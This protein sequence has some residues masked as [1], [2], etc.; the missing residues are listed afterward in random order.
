ML[1]QRLFGSSNRGRV[2]CAAIMLGMATE[3]PCAPV[4]GT[5][6]ALVNGPLDNLE[7]YLARPGIDINERGVTNSTTLLD[8]AAE[9]NNVAVLKYLLDHGAD[10]EATPGL[11]DRKYGLTALHHAAYFDAIDA[12]NFLILR[13]ARIDAHIA[14]DSSHI[15]T[16]TPLILAAQ[17]GHLRMV[18]VLLAHGADVNA[19]Y[20]RNQTAISDALGYGHVDVAH[21]LID[22]GAKLTAR[23]LNDAAMQGHADSVR[24]MLTLP[25]DA[26]AANEAILYATLRGPETGSEPKDI[27]EQLSA[28]GADIDYRVREHDAIPVMFATTPDMIDFLLSHGANGEAKLPGAQL[29]QAYVCNAKVK[30][31]LSVLKVLVAHGVD[32]GGEPS[33]PAV[34]AMNCAL[35]SRNAEVVQYLKNHEDNRDSTMRIPDFAVAPGT[36]PSPEVSEPTP[37]SKVLPPTSS[38]V[39]IIEDLRQRLYAIGETSASV[40]EGVMAEKTAASKIRQYVLGRSNDV[41]IL[42]NATGQTPLIEAAY[43]GYPQVVSALLEFEVVRQHVND[44]DDIGGTAWLYANMALRQS[45]AACNPSVLTDVFA[46][47]PLMV[48]Q[49]FYIPSPDSPYRVIRTALQNNG[50]TGTL[51]EAKRFWV[52]QCKREDSKTRARMEQSSDVLNT[53]THIGVVAFAHF[54]SEQQ[55]KAQLPTK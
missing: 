47:E 9:R 22:R 10:V 50:A 2:I 36:T 35:R 13:G 3:S 21:L 31:P 40:A 14:E 54:L 20:G 42:K 45:V 5:F 24:L 49:Y 18:Q 30:E 51:R 29:A 1:L 4:P 34:S 41:L 17:S 32:I 7:A 26:A 6:T 55:R 28:H 8:I 48:T 33:S 43:D 53:A 12:A 23:G 46:W 25:I 27:I 44:R 19:M 38:P 15:A 39:Q 37:A 52:D 16:P 11:S